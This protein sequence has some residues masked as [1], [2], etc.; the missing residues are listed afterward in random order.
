MPLSRSFYP[1][2]PPNCLKTTRFAGGVIGA[3][4]TE[5]KANKSFSIS[6]DHPVLPNSRFLIAG[7]A[8]CGLTRLRQAR[9]VPPTRNRVFVHPQF[10]QFQLSLTR[11]FSEMNSVQSTDFYRPALKRGTWE[12][13][14]TVSRDN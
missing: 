10:P 4:R 2:R 7:V 13:V 11:N 6:T 12:P 3:Q 5:A 9:F 14:I 8:R 1:H